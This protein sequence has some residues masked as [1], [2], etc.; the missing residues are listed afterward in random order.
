MLLNNEIQRGI[1]TVEFDAILL[2][3]WE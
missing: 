2:L 3:G 1:L